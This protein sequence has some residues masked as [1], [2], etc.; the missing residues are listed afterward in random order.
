[1][2]EDNDALDGL[3]QFLRSLAT[4]L[5][6]TLRLLHSRLGRLEEAEERM[7][8]VAELHQAQLDSLVKAAGA[9]TEAVRALNDKVENIERS[10]SYGGR[11]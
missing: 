5:P 7:T 2:K 11:N 4:D 1:M 10:V 8:T 9:L 3:M 6:E